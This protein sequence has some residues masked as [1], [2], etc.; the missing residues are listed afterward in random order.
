MNSE[1]QLPAEISLEKIYDES[2]YF[3]EK[4]NT[5]YTSILFA[6]LIV[7]GISYFLLGFKSALIVGSVIPLTIFLVLFGCTL[8]GLPLHQTSMT[9][10]IIA[11]GLLIDNAIIVVEDFK[12]RRK[13]GHSREQASYETFQHLWIPLAAATATTALSFFPY[14]RRPRPQRRVC[15]RHGKNSNSFNYFLAFPRA[16]CCTSP[17]KLFRSNKIF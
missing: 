11:L 16:L 14:C 4:F 6:I 2:Y 12:Y 5:L 15:R 7:I 8:L 1:D 9:G 10:I 17:L 3:K 13:L